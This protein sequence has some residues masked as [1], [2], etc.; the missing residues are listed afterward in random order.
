MAQLRL[1]DNAPFTDKTV[2]VVALV[3]P[4]TGEL[5][6]GGG[7]GSGSSGLINF[8]YDRMTASRTSDSPNR[9]ETFTYYQGSTI[10]AVVQATYVND[11]L[12]E[13]KKL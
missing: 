13:I 6:G 3:D 1:P 12:T 11:W 7:S 2:T 5:T 10:V 9:V 8:S 4:V